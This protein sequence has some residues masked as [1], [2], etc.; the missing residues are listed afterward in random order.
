MT[1]TMLYRN[2]RGGT[3]YRI[4]RPI[5]I[6]YGSTEYHPKTQWMMTA[7]DLHKKA[8]RDFAVADCYIT[9]GQEPMRWI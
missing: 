8:D 7:Y 4:V 5:A 3:A 9:H 2:W 6:W 1:I